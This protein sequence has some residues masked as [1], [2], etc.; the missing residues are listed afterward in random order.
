MLVVQPSSDRRAKDKAQ[1]T[2]FLS[3]EGTFG[4][5]LIAHSSLCLRSP[6]RAASRGSQE[7][8]K[9]W[10]CGVWIWSHSLTSSNTGCYLTSQCV[11]PRNGDI[12]IDLANSWKE[13]RQHLAVEPD[14]ALNNLSFPVTA[15]H[16]PTDPIT[17]L[18]AIPFIL[19]FSMPVS[20]LQEPQASQK[21]D[22]KG[23][24]LG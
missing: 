19:G 5:L 15:C 7:G 12:L 1:N 3:W 20:R 17:L 18:S 6:I 21:G 10:I 9:K 8:V 23:K 24:A 13:L 16:P 22:E 2:R 14:Q 11:P 4:C